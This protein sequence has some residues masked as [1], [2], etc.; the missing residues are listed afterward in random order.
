MATNLYET[1][2]VAWTRE[3][4]AELRRLRDARV[5]TRLDLDLLAEEVEDLGSERKFAF[6]SLIEVIIEHLLKLAHSPAVDPR[7]KWMISVQTA[8]RSAARRSTATLRREVVETLEQRFEG[9]RAAAVF[10]MEVYGEIGAIE[11]VPMTNPYSLDQILDPD[12]WPT[13]PE[14][15][16]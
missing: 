14:A 12:F 5:N 4:A 11:S 3:Q 13:A 6:E 10:A 1:D 7:K 16:P 15:R 8:R 2:F 9:A